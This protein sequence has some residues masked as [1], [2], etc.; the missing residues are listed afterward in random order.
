[1]KTGTSTLHA[2]LVA[3]DGIFMSDPK[4]PNFFSDDPVYRR[5]MAWYESLFDGALPGDLKGEASTHYTKRPTYP[6]CIE[7]MSKTLPDVKLIYVTRDPIDR[8]ISH[9]IHEW[10]QNVISCDLNEALDR[11]PEL[12]AYSR[13]AYQ[14][15]PYLDHF[16]PEQIFIANQAQMRTCPQALLERLGIF[17]GC[18]K[19]LIW[20]DNIDA[21]NVSAERIRRFPLYSLLVDNSLAEMLRRN[22]VPQ[23]IRSRVKE[24][25]QMKT[26]PELTKD[27]QKRLNE[28]FSKDQRHLEALE[29]PN[30]IKGAA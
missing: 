9:Y 23:S 25:Y 20:R 4:E 29:L 11:H 1:M 21:R 3:Q 24:R 30:M 2:Q 28:I 7:R 8:L 17:L 14:L 5:G 16:A 19:P 26:R 13:Y 6:D 10:T 15:E 27:A 12:I 18:A 22:L